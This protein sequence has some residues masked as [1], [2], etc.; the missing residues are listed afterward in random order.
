MEIMKDEVEEKQGG[1]CISGCSP[2]SRLVAYFISLTARE[3]P[4]KGE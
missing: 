3:P 4:V 2:G 1:I